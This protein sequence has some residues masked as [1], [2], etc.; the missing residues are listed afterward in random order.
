MT[1]PATTDDRAALPASSRIAHSAFG[2]GPRLGRLLGV[3]LTLDLS[4]LLVFGLVL[5]NLGGGVLPAWH[6]FWSPGLRWAVAFAASL[7]FFASIL[8]HELSHAL[9]GRALG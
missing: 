5:L 7:L 1:N 3:E 6:P 8:L 9:A 4:L 2:P